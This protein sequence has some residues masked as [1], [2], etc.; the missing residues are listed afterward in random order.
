M[1]AC[2]PM[3]ATRM[4]IHEMWRWRLP[5][6]RQCNVGEPRLLEGAGTVC[7]SRETGAM[8]RSAARGGRRRAVTRRAR[9]PHVHVVIARVMMVGAGRVAKA[10]A[11]CMTTVVT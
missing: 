7:R 6:L 10:A 9:P 11:V 4:Q 5:D 2:P 8:G 3:V 1:T